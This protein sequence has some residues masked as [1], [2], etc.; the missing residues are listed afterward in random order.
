MYDVPV[1]FNPGGTTAVISQQGIFPTGGLVNM[2]IT[3]VSLDG[4]VSQGIPVMLH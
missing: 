2:E 3:P 4:C 1:Q